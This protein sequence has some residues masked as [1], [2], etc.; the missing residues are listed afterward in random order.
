MPSTSTTGSIFTHLGVFLMGAG[1]A[2]LGFSYYLRDKIVTNRNPSEDDL[3]NTYSNVCLDCQP[4]ETQECPSQDRPTLEINVPSLPELNFPHL[5][6]YQYVATK[7]GRNPMQ[8][9]LILFP[10]QLRMGYPGRYTMSKI[11]TIPEE[12]ILSEENPLP[13]NTVVQSQ[14]QTQKRLMVSEEPPMSSS[15]ATSVLPVCERPETLAQ[16]AECALMDT[17]R[18]VASS[19]PQDSHTPQR[20]LNDSSANS[21]QQCSV[22]SQQSNPTSEVLESAPVAVVQDS[23]VSDA[24]SQDPSK[25]NAI[26]VLASMKEESN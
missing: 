4:D 2:M 12:T 5:G 18:T 9:R 15:D 24:T 26:L 8:H 7:S 21:V 1:A 16:S 22:E 11:T 25:N 17:Q 14:N 23:N 20:S 10:S 6:V 13:S 19:I 3:S